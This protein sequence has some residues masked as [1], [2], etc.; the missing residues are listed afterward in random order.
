L[1]FASKLLRAC[2]METAAELKLT[3]SWPLEVGSVAR[4]M[5]LAA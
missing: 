3:V 5:L 1:V 2:A 4:A